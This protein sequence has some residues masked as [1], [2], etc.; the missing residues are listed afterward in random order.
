MP[1]R[2]KIIKID[3]VLVLR[4]LCL[5]L[6]NCISG[7]QKFKKNFRKK[8]F[9]SIFGISKNLKNRFFF[10]KKFCNLD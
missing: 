8:S 7:I 10:Y 6:T 1:N 2:I 3:I 9:Y 4:N 5:N